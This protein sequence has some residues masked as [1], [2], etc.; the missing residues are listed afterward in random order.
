MKKQKIDNNL[1]AYSYK[2]AMKVSFL[3]TSEEVR[4]Y[5]EALCE[6]MM[7]GNSVK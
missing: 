6:A 1:L 4:M 7:W 5:A 2:E 3:E